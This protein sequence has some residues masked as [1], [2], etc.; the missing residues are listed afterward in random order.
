MDGGL[1][2]CSSSVGIAVRPAVQKLNMLRGRKEE[3][4]A[5]ILSM[6]EAGEIDSQLVDAVAIDEGLAAGPQ[7]A[8]R[9]AG[10]HSPA[11]A[12]TDA[13][14][15]SAWGLYG[16]PAAIEPVGFDGHETAAWAAAS[17][18]AAEAPEACARGHAGTSSAW[19]TY[20]SPEDLSEHGKEADSTGIAAALTHEGT[21][22]G[23]P[24]YTTDRD[25]VLQSVRAARKERRKHQRHS[26]H[27]QAE[28]ASMSGEK[29]Q[30]AGDAVDAAPG[31]RG[32][33]SDSA[34]NRDSRSSEGKPEQVGRSDRAAGFAGGESLDGRASMAAGE[35][36]TRAGAG[37]DVA[38]VAAPPP[39]SSPSPQ[40]R[41]PS[42]PPAPAV[43][44]SSVW[45]AFV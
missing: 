4:E 8:R 45:A 7:S 29:R 3:L 42:P 31:G 44:P 20:M 15:H 34:L 19:A 28:A 6:I 36:T 32:C 22:G 18:A 5:T 27:L 38:M 41:T 16:D 17:L 14:H 1:V 13:D 11:A 12:L 33:H 30:R 9:A 40:A 39:R 23:E 24:T 25:A 21:D 26:G 37:A 43:D 35:G 2:L 10:T